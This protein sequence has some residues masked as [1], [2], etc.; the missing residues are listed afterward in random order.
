MPITNMWNCIAPPF[1]T[2]AAMVANSY[3][4]TESMK[5]GGLEG[6]L[7][8]EGERGTSNWTC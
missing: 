1:D 7:R 5:M 4:W 3:R 6:W 8:S 2:A